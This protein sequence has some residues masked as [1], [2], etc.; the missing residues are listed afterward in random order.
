M[1]LFH[2][3]K[4]LLAFKKSHFPLD[5]WPPLYMD[6]EESKGKDVISE[7]D[8][9]VSSK[10]DDLLFEEPEAP[11][12]LSKSGCWPYK[13]IV[14][15]DPIPIPVTPSHEDPFI[16]NSSPCMLDKYMQ[17]AW[18][19][20]NPDQPLS[21]GDKISTKRVDR[22]VLE[23]IETE[24]KSMEEIVNKTVEALKTAAR[25]VDEELTIQEIR[26]KI[27]KKEEAKK[28]TEEKANQQTEESASEEEEIFIVDVEKSPENTEK[29]PQEEC[30]TP[31]KEVI[32]QEKN[33]EVTPD[34]AA[35]PR[36]PFLKLIKYPNVLFRLSIALGYL[37]NPD[38]VK[39]TLFIPAD[40]DTPW[41]DQLLGL[42][43]KRARRQPIRVDDF[44][45]YMNHKGYI[46]LPNI[47][48][49]KRMLIAQRYASSCEEIEYE[50]TDDDV[51]YHPLYC[52]ICNVV[53]HYSTIS[54]PQN[55][56]TLFTNGP[57]LIADLKEDDSWRQDAQ[58]ICLGVHSLMYMPSNQKYR[59]I[60]IGNE[61]EWEYSIPSSDTSLYAPP[62]T[63]SLSLIWHINNV[64]SLLGP[65]IY[66]PIFVEFYENPKY[67]G[68]DVELH[69]AGFANALRHCQATYSG[70]IVGLISPVLGVEGDTL[71]IYY[72]KK[73]RLAVKQ[74]AGHLIGQALGVP[75]LHIPVQVTEYTNSD[76][77]L[78]YPYWNQEPIVTDTGSPTREYFQRL[79]MWF[80]YVLLNLFL[81]IPVPS[82][83]T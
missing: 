81:N 9:G 44:N 77:G 61:A 12:D 29:N 47:M 38:T 49:I 16:D 43:A 71:E 19:K 35:R 8:P 68:A 66:I 7:N 39:D 26:E 83:L 79:E 50:C 59:I 30:V 80:D 21:A 45:F 42:Q 11:L 3:Q 5:F 58:A 28:V 60:N 27:Q 2:N 78:C 76:A 74:V 24:E 52:R 6:M 36:R 69:V 75:I 22:W 53:H 17:E 23:M 64:I 18:N 55:C 54:H 32:A 48:T 31:E 33:V 14:P 34:V 37:T 1:E 41:T 15:S 65:D 10:G 13:V 56:L 46:Y 20:H 82:R 25:T 73:E 40:L 4:L 67:P 63:H 62:V 51:Y 57:R 70:P 72:R